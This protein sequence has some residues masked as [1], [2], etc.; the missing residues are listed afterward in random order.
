M[1]G[2]I[3][4]LSWQVSF[5]KNETSHP[6][7]RSGRSE[8]TQTRII[9]VA[10]D[11]FAKEGYAGVS[12]SEIVEQANVTTGAIYHH[13]KDKKGL[14]LA[15][16]E[17]LEQ[18][19]MDY[20]IALPPRDDPWETFIQG[21]GAT[22]EICARPDINRI[23]FKEAPSVIGP[24][25]WREIEVQYAFGMMQA[26]ISALADAGVLDA[27]DPGLTS[28]I[29]L[30]SIIEAAHAVASAPVPEAALEDAKSA[31]LKMVAALHTQ[32]LGHAQ[33]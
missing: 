20:V 1:F 9:S 29:I 19:I 24:A 3:T 31:V 16:A 10:R 21:I 6:D 32:D 18:E 8:A 2:D 33:T 22:L 5:M 11:A 7:R 15:V 23:V 14:F 17:A 12:L 25:E 13:F 28:Q 4:K 30:G 26:A 27:P